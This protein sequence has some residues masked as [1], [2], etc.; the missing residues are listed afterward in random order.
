MK[1]FKHISDNNYPDIYIDP[2]SPVYEFITHMNSL[3]NKEQHFL[4]YISSFKYWN[5]PKISLWSLKNILNYIDE[6]LLKYSNDLSE[7]NINNKIQPIL[8]FT[9][10]LLKNSTCN[11][12]FASFDTLSMIFLKTFDIKTKV[13]IL[14]IFQIIQ[15][16][17]ILLLDYFSAI[18]KPK[19]IFIN[20]RQILVEFMNNNFKF[21]ENILS[22]LE[23]ILLKQ[24]NKW[25]NKLI[26]QENNNN[27]LIK[28]EKE[29]IDPIIIFKEIIYK[30]KDYRNKD[31]FPEVQKEYNYFDLNNIYNSSNND[32]ISID[33]KE[34]IISVNNFFCIINFLAM[35]NNKKIE[36]NE[37]YLLFKLTFIV[38][39]LNFSYEPNNKDKIITE[40]YKESFMKDML[41]ILSNKNS[42]K[43]KIEFLFHY[44]NIFY[45]DNCHK[46][47]LFQNNLINSILEDMIHINGNNLNVLEKEDSYNQYFLKMILTCCFCLEKEIPKFILFNIIAPPKDNIYLYNIYNVLYCLYNIIRIDQNFTVNH[48]IPRLLYELQHLNSQEGELKYIFANKNDIIIGYPTIVDRINLIIL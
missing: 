9:L 30:N 22:S 25:N 21:N 27:Q 4:N 17:L 19:Y 10:L 38:I 29:K 15:K 11:D 36:I 41:L 34:Y 46:H 14:E 28:E 32:D 13:L 24:K 7:I 26:Q 1:I 33:E 44:I 16:D 23:Q 6:L 5:L 12:I 20:I 37:I 8:N 40:D 35:M 3:L 47:I 48:L 43:I 45:F 42:I 39:H 2:N 31:Q 18:I